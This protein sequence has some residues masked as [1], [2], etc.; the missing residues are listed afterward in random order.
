MPFQREER[1]PTPT[2][3]RNLFVSLVV[4]QQIRGRP[5]YDIPW[6]RSSI[7][8]II[9][10]DRLSCIRRPSTFYVGRHTS[11]RLR[12]KTDFHRAPTSPPLSSRWFVSHIDISNTI[13]GID[14]SKFGSGTHRV[15]ASNLAPW[16]RSCRADVFLIDT[17]NDPA[18]VAE[19]EP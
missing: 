3:S 19:L 14:I 2:W 12:T 7:A 1:A 18:L 10:Y 13:Y 4:L 16:S 5:R 9:A 8:C 11:C 17:K 6:Y 15:R